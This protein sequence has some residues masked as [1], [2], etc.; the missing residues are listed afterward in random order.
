LQ[1]AGLSSNDIS[2]CVKNHGTKGFSD[3]MT[4]D[5]QNHLYFGNQANS[6]V[7]SCKM[8]TPIEIAKVVVQNISTMQWPDTF[9]WDNTEESL[10]FV[11]NKLQLFAFDGMKFDG[12]DGSNFRIWKVNVKAHSYL[13]KNPIPTES[14]CLPDLI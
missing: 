13:S 4:S 1:I 11:S 7:M 8:G 6:A 5:D 14:I 9:A 12:S 2:P 3:G 10:I